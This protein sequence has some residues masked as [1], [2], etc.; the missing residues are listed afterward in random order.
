MYNIIPLLL[1]L[2]SLSLIIV[3]VSRKFSVLA[4]LDVENI[5][6]E[7]EAKFKERIVSN[8][9]KRNIIKYWS[10][11]GR[12]LAP[13]SQSA[14][15]YLKSKLNKLYQAKNVYQEN[16]RTDGPEAIDQLFSQAEELKKRDELDLA[17]KK[18][19]E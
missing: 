10:K 15:D 18:Y 4:A 3:I 2:I 14:G 8:R 12:V 11:T 19:I 13:L 5:P 17:E 9:L 1:I 16:F 7:K 6:A